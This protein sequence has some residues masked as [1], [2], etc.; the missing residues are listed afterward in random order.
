M[1]IRTKKFVAI[2]SICIVAFIFSLKYFHAKAD[3]ARA[4]LGAYDTVVSPNGEYKIKNYY[5]SSGEPM[6]LLFQVFDHSENLIAEYTR[7]VWPGAAT[8][9]WICDEGPCTE[10]IFETGDTDPI[11]LPPTWLDRLRAKIP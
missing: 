4:K 1:N 6:V 8:E 2:G 7:D 5:I 3:R 11:K 10:Y 9:N